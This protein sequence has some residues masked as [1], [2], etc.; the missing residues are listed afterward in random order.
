MSEPVLAQTGIEFLL[1][2]AA[3]SAGLS[4]IIAG[5]SRFFSRKKKEVDITIEFK[6]GTKVKLKSDDVTP[7]QIQTILDSFAED[8]KSTPP[9]RS[10]ESGAVVLDL[11]LLVIPGIIALLFAGTFIYLLLQH[12]GNP[13]YST[14]Q[15]LQSALTTIIGYYFGLGASTALNSGSTVSEGQLREMLQTQGKATEGP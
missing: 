9:P 13:E 15:E 4:S 2:A 5:I 1:A 3:A 8:P 14:P 10:P 11:L 6:D 12:Q 7:E